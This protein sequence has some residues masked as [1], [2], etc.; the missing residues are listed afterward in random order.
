MSAPNP[1]AAVVVREHS[2]QPFYEAS[3]GRAAGQTAPRPRVA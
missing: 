2:G 3:S 1:T